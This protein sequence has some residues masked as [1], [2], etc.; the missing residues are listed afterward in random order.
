MAPNSIATF[1]YVLVDSLIT[2]GLQGGSLGVSLGRFSE[3]ITC[4][5]TAIVNRRVK[6]DQVAA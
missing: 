1:L 5:L 3:A 2:H 4:N 6:R